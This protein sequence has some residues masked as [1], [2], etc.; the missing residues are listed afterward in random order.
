MYMFVCVFRFV[1]IL[2]TDYILSEMSLYCGECG[3]STV[4]LPTGHW[5]KCALLSDATRGR[6]SN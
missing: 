5:L 6:A 3:C 4:M 1:A 2:R